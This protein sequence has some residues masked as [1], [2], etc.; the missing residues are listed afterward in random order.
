[1]VSWSK[2]IDTIDL[3]YYTVADGDRQAQPAREADVD[4]GS[5]T[6]SATLRKRLLIR[7][8]GFNLGLLMRQLIGVCVRPGAA[9]AQRAPPVPRASESEAPPLKLRRLRARLPGG[10]AASLLRE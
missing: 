8:G 6:R 2:G 7:S 10:G 9:R 4:V 3:T 1:M 5:D